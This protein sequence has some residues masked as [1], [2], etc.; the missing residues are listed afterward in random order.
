MKIS[1]RELAAIRVL[2]CYTWKD[3]HQPVLIK[4]CIL[5]TASL[6]PIIFSLGMHVFGAFPANPDV[7]QGLLAESIQFSSLYI[8]SI[9]FTVPFF[10]FCWESFNK[11]L[12]FAFS[13]KIAP[14]RAK[15]PDGFGLVVLLAVVAYVV[16]TLFYASNENASFLLSFIIYVTS[17]FV[18]YIM[19]LMSHDPDVSRGYNE[20]LRSNEN[21]AL[22][23]FQ[24][25][26][27]EGSDE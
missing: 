7:S 12:P 19:L 23:N 24:D 16:S 5:L 26:L 1:L 9:A 22:A 21:S 4:F 14:E 11:L 25:Q 17:L 27:S 18:W 6:S 15:P 10:F 20:R 2:R 8:Y 3:Y 13:E